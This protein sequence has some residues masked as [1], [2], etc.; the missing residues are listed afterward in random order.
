GV[1]VY[2]ETDNKHQ[3]KPEAGFTYRWF[4]AGGMKWGID[5][6]G[7]GKIDY[8]KLISAEEVSQEVFRALATNDGNRLKALF[9]SE[10]ELRALKLPA[11]EAERIRRQM[12]QAPAKFQETVRKLPKLGD[13]AF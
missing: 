3:N 5:V 12:Q 10:A 9:L 6:N 13:D 2:R 7:D 8:W 11:A 1:E 4:N